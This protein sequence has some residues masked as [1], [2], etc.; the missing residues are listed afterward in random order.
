[1]PAVSKSQFRLFKGICEGS[2]DPIPGM[3]RQQAC[4]YVKGQS[5][6]G[7]PKKAK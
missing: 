3:T 5:P 1:M 2:I 4:E 6:K 7:L